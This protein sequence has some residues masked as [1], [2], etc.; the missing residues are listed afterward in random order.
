FRQQEQDAGLPGEMLSLGRLEFLDD[1]L[2]LQVNSAQRLQAA[3]R[4]LEAIPQ[5]ECLG[6]TTRR[7][8]ASD[9]PMDDRMGPEEPSEVTPEMASQLEQYL[10]RHYI[11]WLD[12]PLAALDG[13][14]PREAC[15]TEAGRRKVAMLIRTIPAP[16]GNAGVQVEVPRR[17]MLQQLGLEPE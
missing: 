3:R 7:L 17:E 14:T 8:D 16:E 9:I 10:H 6:V 12:T 15:D 2:V 1:E 5:V 13:K 4:W 11:S